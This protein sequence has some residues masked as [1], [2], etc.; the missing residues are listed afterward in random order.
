[1]STNEPKLLQ[2]GI[3]SSG[4][5]TAEHDERYVLS[6]RPPALPSKSA[7]AETVIASGVDAGE[8]SLA[9]RPLFPAETVKTTPS[10]LAPLSASLTAGE[11]PPPRLMFA[12][13]RF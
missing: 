3:A 11:Y 5:G 12:T 8:K 13:S 9:S 7:T 2:Q 4:M 6:A 10:W 1:M